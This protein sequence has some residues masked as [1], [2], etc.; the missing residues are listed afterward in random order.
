[1][2]SLNTCEKHTS[3]EPPIDRIVHSDPRSR[4][5]PRRWGTPQ[6]SAHRFHLG[7][8]G[9]AA[10]LRGLLPTDRGVAHL[11]R[12][13]P[14]TRR[15]ILPPRLC[16]ASSLPS[17]PSPRLGQPS[18]P[19]PLGK[20]H[21]A[22]PH[23]LRLLRP[24][25]RPRPS[26]ADPAEVPRVHRKRRHEWQ[27]PKTPATAR[28]AVCSRRRDQPFFSRTRRRQRSCQPA[29]SS[30]SRS[31]RSPAA[32][33]SLA[34]AEVVDDLEQRRGARRQRCCSSG[35]EPSRPPSAAGPRRCSTKPGR[36]RRRHRWPRRTWSTST[37]WV[38]P[39]RAPWP[40]LGQACWLWV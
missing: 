17:A 13:L 9:T 40:F 21:D 6:T 1:M 15:R 27:S 3:S 14:R 19:G 32:N 5:R 24:L 34:R 30:T 35:C 8:Y 31:T 20:L 29:E 2:R 36:P 23:L 37:S 38:G 33:A 28:H 39:A 22:K 18:T 16:A 12:R 25:R 7:T 10:V 11:D 4:T 26:G